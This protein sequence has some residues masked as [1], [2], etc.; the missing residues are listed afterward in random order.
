MRFDFERDALDDFESGLSQRL[1]L[2]RVVRHHAYGAQSESEQ[3]F[4]ALLVTAH[5][6]RETESLVSFDCVG[7]LVLLRGSANLVDDA[8]AAAFLLL[9]DDGAVSFL[10]DEFHCSLELAATVAFD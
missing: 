5:I 2:R 3:D 7:A 4:S 6:G 9:V 1:D 10:L 8:D